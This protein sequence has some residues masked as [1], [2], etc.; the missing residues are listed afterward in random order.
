MQVS[1][2]YEKESN[3]FYNCL[4]DISYFPYWEQN[5]MATIRVG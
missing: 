4:K 3:I 5:G 2:K 1:T